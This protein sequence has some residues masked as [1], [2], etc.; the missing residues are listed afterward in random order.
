M[1]QQ[2]NPWEMDWTGQSGAPSGP[3]Y[4]APPKPEK[5]NEPKTTW[6]QGVVNG[7]PVQISSEGKIE[8]L[9]GKD[10]P[11]RTPDQIEAAKRQLRT[12]L[13]K[14]DEVAIDSADNSGWFE[15]GL[16]GSITRNIPGTAAYDLAGNVKTIDANA[17][18][19]KLQQMRE[20]SPTGGALGQVTEKELDLL[21]SS[22]ANLDTGQGQEQFFSNLAGAKRV[23]LDMLAKLD[24]AEAE[25]YAKRKGIRWNERGQAILAPVDGDIAGLRETDPLGIAGGTPPGDGGNP[26]EGGG[27]GGLPDWAKSLYAGVGDLAE[28]A[29]DVYG[30]VANPFIATYNAVTGNNYN[31]DTGQ[32]FR[33][34]IGAPQ[35]NQ[36]ASAINR[37]AAGALMFGGLARGASNVATGVTQNALA[38]FGARPVLDTVAGGAAGAGAEAGR[39]S[40]IP[41]GEAIGTL[42]GGLAGYSGAQRFANAV[43]P[44][45]PTAVAQAAE[46]QGVQMIPGDTG[47][48]ATRILTSGAKASPLSAGPIRTQ[49][50]QSQAQLE[51]AASRASASQG[52]RMTT[53]KA[54]EA[55]RQAATNYIE[56]TSAR[57]ETLYNAAYQSAG[58]VRAIKP[59]KTIQALDEQI[60]R[61]KQNPTDEAAGMVGELTAFRDRIANGVSIQGLRDARTSLSAGVYD[62]KLR[63]NQ[64]QGMWKKILGNVAG[65]IDAG[66]RAAGKNK[67]AELFRRADAFHSQK[68]EHIDEVLS[69]LLGREKGGEQII[70]TL[71]QMARGKAGGN[72]RLSR[73]L[74]EMSPQEAGQ[75]RATLIE[76]IGKA[77]P[78]Q[79]DETGQ[80]FSSDAF[81][82]SW[83]KMTPQAKASLFPNEEMR[84]NLNDIALISANMK[85][86][87][88]MANFSNT[89]MAV[90]GGGQSVGAVAL[91][92]AVSPIASAVIGGGQY[93]TGKLLASPGFARWLAR[94]PKN[95]RAAM[96]YSEQLSVLGTREPLIANDAKALQEY[97]SQAF[98]QSPG[99]AAAQEEDNGRVKPPQQ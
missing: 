84:R 33:D 5:P 50:R 39:V 48:T 95:P 13:D 58:G 53:D 65:D 20:N 4:G 60:A 25:A 1:A 75:I 17:A 82:T 61:L 23:Y 83:N 14:I 55:V 73:L 81:L 28:S 24:P 71:E 19:D 68:V 35:G 67:A 41:G 93:L 47:G 51:Q 30:I 99:R 62:G 8:A 97:L 11:Q 87:N 36:T 66:L 42:A 70:E 89:A 49:A 94:A 79:Q 80:V 76:R 92:V 2:Q 21:K 72:A 63:S 98:S 27:G 40:G 34:A 16:S 10:D 69:P 91:G 54:G 96:K 7:K 90:G 3:V 78:G 18:F 38:T 29:G 86:S 77:S 46:R 74:G 22:I 57:G 15:T 52:E 31:T 12:V 88:S 56:R 9:P 64:V 6:T 32:S 43:A 44:K 26:P 45:V 85:Q 37:G 59:V